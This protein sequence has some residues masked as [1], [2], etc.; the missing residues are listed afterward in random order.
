LSPHEEGTPSNPPHQQSASE[1]PLYNTVNR[2]VTDALE[3]HVKRHG[4][5]KSHVLEALLIILCLWLVLLISDYFSYAPWINS[6]RYSA[7]FHVDRT[8]V[9]QYEDKP[10]SDCDFLSSPIGYKGC[11][12]KKHV[13]VLPPSADNGNKKTI[14]VYWS[15]ENGN[16]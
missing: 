5:E 13:D 11:H 10:P 9:L 15:H 6:L 4:E 14:A 8:Q 16:Y 7:W 3:L 2:A 12:Y 1:D